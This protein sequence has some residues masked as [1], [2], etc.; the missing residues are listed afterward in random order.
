[1]NIK[2]HRVA[3][4]LLLSLLHLGA[5]PLAVAQ[6]PGSEAHEATAPVVLATVEVRDTRGSFLGISSASSAGSFSALKLSAMSIQRPADV[7]EAIPGLIV[8][9]HAGNGKA[10]QYFLRGFSLDHGTDFAS[11]VGGVPVN[12]PG[13]AHGQGYSDLNFLIP[14]LIDKVAFRKGPYDA[15]DGDFSSAGTAQI[16]YKRTLASSLAQLTLGRGNYQ[17]GLLAGSRDSAQGHW[18]YGLEVQHED[19]PWTVPEGYRKFNAVLRLSQGSR[20][21]GW[22]VTG[23]A[24]RGRWT[25]TDQVAQRAID[26]GLISRY[27]SLDPSSGGETFRYSLAADW[28][29]KGKNS[30]TLG[31]LWLLNSG[32]DLWSNFQ[33]CLNDIAATGTCARGDQFRQSERRLAFG[34]SL[35]HRMEHSWGERAISTSM[36]VQTR[37]DLISPVSLANTQQRNDVQILRE[38]RVRQASLGL[39]WQSEIRWTD[40]LRT[41]AGLRAD[42]FQFDVRSNL[43]GNSGSARDQMITPKLSLVLGPW[44]KTE[45]YF[46]YG[47]G[48]HSNDAR[49]TTQRV[50][51]ANPAV[52][53]NPAS[54]LVRTRGMELGLRKAWD[55]GW[56]T[57]LAF[58]HMSSASELLFVGDAGTTEASRA[59]SR[60]GVE[61]SNTYPLNRWLTLDADLA[62]SHA[63]FKDN[64]AQGNFIPGALGFTANLGLS[65]LRNGPW[66]GSLRLRYVG[67]RP[68]LEDNSVRSAPSLITNFRLV[69]ALTQRMDLSLDIHNLFNRQNNDIEYWYASQLRGESAATLDRHVHP[70]EPRSARLTL[71]L[72]Y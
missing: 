67:A 36:G 62:A 2:P 52:S 57:S 21:D 66:S 23:M 11:F 48:F 70:G 12:M 10:N 9:Q 6:T 31:N 55:S 25:S 71:S 16:E 41:S 35:S 39:W 64:A 37:A 13:H 53:V 17:R 59:S 14:E 61:W 7:L 49:G 28:A 47:H 4:P 30:Q 18:L 45:I 46:N 34:S 38:D 5:C 29:R 58:W 50:D 24:Y 32:L 8:T 15:Q 22:S 27:G 42:A 69:H 54:P 60:Y 68:L 1:M 51:P 33:Y 20:S 43:A 65:V 63:R 44:E 72:R 56:Q 3:I 40:W 26:S 19:G